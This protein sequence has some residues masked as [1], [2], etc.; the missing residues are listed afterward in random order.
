MYAVN[1]GFVDGFERDGLRFRVRDGG[2][3]NGE[4]VVLLH[5]FPQD[6]TCW[7]EVEPLLH[8]GGC[9]T[10]APDQRGYSP[11]ARPRHT[12]AYAVRELVGDVLALL[13]TAGAE[14]AHIVG[15][16]WGAA[17][18]WELA[19][20]ASHRVATLTTLST[21]HP[22]AFRQALR[23]PDQRKRSWYMAAFQVPVLPER[24]LLRRLGP[25][26]R[27]S[28]LPPER[29]AHYVA[30]F[31]TTDDL[32]GPIDWYRDALPRSRPRS[33]PRLR[34]AAGE[35]KRPPRSTLVT[36]PT[37]YL[38]G[39]QDEALGARGAYSTEEYVSAPYR[40]VELEAGH[41]LPEC[42]AEVVAREVLQRVAGTT[43]A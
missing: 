8:A 29:V 22:T 30:R 10:L 43:P 14:R 12:G 23:T 21:P 27:R 24:M 7:R 5:G 11:Q 19:I 20:R 37:T 40:F 25:T 16:D 18:A 17:V 9:R 32:R 36:V 38:W 28:G 13:D 39:S 33:R 34:P 42:Q 2:P 35:A 15:H 6:S 31:A 1:V 41:W 3:V 26:L 4:P